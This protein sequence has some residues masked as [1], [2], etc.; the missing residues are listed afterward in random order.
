MSGVSV[1]VFALGLGVFAGLRSLTPPAAVAWAAHMNWIDLQRS[2]LRF[3]GSP[4]T[5]IIL[6][7]LAIGELVIDKL[8]TTP[9]RKALFPFLGRILTG[10]FSGGVMCAGADRSPVLGAMLGAV[11][12]L[13]G[14]LVGYEVRTRSV[15]AL[16]VPDFVVA[17]AEDVV[18]V[19]GSLLIVS[20]V[21]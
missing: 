19:G 11:G 17:L 4:I 21:G 18:A 16:K 14:T 13:I 9:S 5:V 15:K 20:H 10:G 12:G 8:P 7:L 2:A 1:L 3:M 6:A